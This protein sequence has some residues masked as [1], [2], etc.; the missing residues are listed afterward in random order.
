M[1]FNEKEDKVY[2]ASVLSEAQARVAKRKFEKAVECKVQQ[3]EQM[4]WWERLFPY[5]ITITKKKNLNKEK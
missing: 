2:S 1:S 5:T 4:K 3:L